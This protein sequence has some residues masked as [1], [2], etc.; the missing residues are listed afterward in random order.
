[1][2]PLG[3]AAAYYFHRLILDEGDTEE[4]RKMAIA[5]LQA[6]EEFIRGKGLLKRTTQLHQ[7]EGDF[8]LQNHLIPFLCFTI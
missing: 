3:Q 2:F 6:S 8:A 7:H 4:S 1:L 5:A